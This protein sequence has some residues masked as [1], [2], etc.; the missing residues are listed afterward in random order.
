MV[1]WLIPFIVA[2]SFCAIKYTR[3]YYWL[4]F[5]YTVDYYTTVL[6]DMLHHAKIKLW[7]QSKCKKAYAAKVKDSMFCAGYDYG[8]IDSC[9]VSETCCLFHLFSSFESFVDSILNDIKRWQV[10]RWCF[11]RETAGVP[12][13]AGSG[14]TGCWWGWPRGGSHRAD[15]STSRGCIP[16]W[17]LSEGGLQT[18]PNHQVSFEPLSI[19]SQRIK[20][21]RSNIVHVS[22]IL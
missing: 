11:H 22:D 10:T 3:L 20:P 16:E 13:S 15:S 18:S 21:C 5:L 7:S 9:K 6:P 12:W 17:T 19:F 8:G 4:R 1:N 14:T 2:R